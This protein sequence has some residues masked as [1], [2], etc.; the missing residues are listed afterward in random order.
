MDSRKY[1]DLICRLEQC[2]EECRAAKYV[3]VV[4]IVTTT[5]LVAA[6]LVLVGVL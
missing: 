3:S 6:V 1:E 2:E 4:N 5:L